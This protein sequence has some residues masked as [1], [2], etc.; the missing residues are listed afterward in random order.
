M[1]DAR[2]RIGKGSRLT[3]HECHECSDACRHCI[4]HCLRLSGLHADARRI[5]T[6]TDCAEAC[7]FAASFLAR[8]SDHAVRACAICAEVCD[9]CALSCERVPDD[10]E[11]R[12][13]AQCCRRCAQ[14]CRD[15]AGVQS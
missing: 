13:C 7:E 9:A 6:L 4:Q 3:L 1:R 5:R 14:A 12:S 10:E 15:M 2:D 11:M 8:E